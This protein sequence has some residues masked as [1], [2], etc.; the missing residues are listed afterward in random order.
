MVGELVFFYYFL[1]VLKAG[2]L[3]LFTVDQEFF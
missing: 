1:E 3:N 2:G